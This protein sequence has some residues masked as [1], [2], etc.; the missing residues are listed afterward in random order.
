MAARP[1]K[2]G[3]IADL[4]ANLPALTAVIQ[5]LRT[6]GVQQILCLGD[7]VGYYAQPREVVDLISREKAVSICGN[8]DRYVTGTTPMDSSIRS[9]TIQV[10]QWT[11]RHLA[12]GQLQ[13]LRGLPLSRRVGDSILMVHGSPRHED[14]YILTPD[15]VAMNLRFLGRHHPGIEVCF[16]GHSHLPVYATKGY[17]QMQ[18][19]GGEKL[20]LRRH[21]AHLINPG[22]VGQPRDG[23]PRAACAIYDAA[24]SEVQFLRIDYD[25]KK[26]QQKADAAGFSS[27]LAE[28]L[29]YGR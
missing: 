28:R 22:S 3:L 10:I 21:Q 25:Y 19:S 23:D 13:Y 11:V 7:I 9:D 14:E 16:F 12:P 20:R 18:F 29:E 5:R 24:K 6:E 2:F 8:H 4:H 15:L 27:R 26:T 1:Q 17:I